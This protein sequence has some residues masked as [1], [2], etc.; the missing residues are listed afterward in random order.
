MRALDDLVASGGCLSRHQLDRHMNQPA[1]FLDAT[2]LL[3][4]NIVAKIKAFSLS[5]PGPAPALVP[6]PVPAADG[7][8]EG[9]SVIEED[10]KEESWWR[11]VWRLFV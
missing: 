9:D 11:W 8:E 7:E 3:T 4:R 2:V 5:T 1:G 6:V 10:E